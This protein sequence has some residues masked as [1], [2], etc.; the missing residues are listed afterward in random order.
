MVCTA[1]GTENS[2]RVIHNSMD[3]RAVQSNYT[4][5]FITRWPAT[6]QPRSL[7]LPPSLS[8]LAARKA[9]STF[10]LQASEKLTLT[11]GV[12]AT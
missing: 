12:L 1:E 9:E 8:L 5:I 11:P 10:T 6:R 4:I 2:L 3:T 7:S